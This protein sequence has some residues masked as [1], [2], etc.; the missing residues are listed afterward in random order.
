MKS[1]TRGVTRVCAA[2]AAAV[3][4]LAACTDA[5]GGPTAAPT[6]GGTAP[7]DAPSGETVTLRVLSG[8]DDGSVF[9]G[10]LDILIPE[11]EE[12]S[13]GRIQV[14]VAGPEVVPFTEGIGA[15]GSGVYD[16]LYTVPLFNTG[17][18]PEGE[19]IYFITSESS[20]AEYRD[21]GA[22]D[23]YDEVHREKANVF[24]LGCGG[25]GAHGAT[26]L[27]TERFESLDDFNGK[28]FRGFG[29]YTRVLDT[30]GAS[31]VA[32]PPPDIYGAIERGV[33]DGAAFPNLGIH[34][35]ALYEV[36]PYILMPPYLPFR[37]AFYMN[38]EA[39]DALPADI[40]ELLTDT[41][42]DL[43]PEFDAYWVERR[44][45]EEELLRGEGMEFVNL[46]ADESAR[47]EETVFT[48]MWAFL[49]ETSPEYSTQLREAF[50][51]V[52]GR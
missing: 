15:V 21:A 32:M 22:L 20:C 18:V 38:P 19:L 43:E 45:A 10:P 37:Y 36:A 51:S 33:V 23:L 29:L 35:Q 49:D 28:V 44:D 1:P 25:G 50:E 30:L 40:Q 46:P 4:V 27:T 52:E 31:S 34:E 9:N 11:L 16:I 26:F 6:Q 3:L 5:G 14:E 12:R 42:W 17:Q 2:A 39:Y 41:V 48:E 8:F 13:N 7:T 47:L 24:L